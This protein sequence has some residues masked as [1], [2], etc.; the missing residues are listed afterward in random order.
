MKGIKTFRLSLS[1]VLA[2]GILF[3]SF[4]VALADDPPADRI[5]EDPYASWG[6]GFLG[7]RATQ[8]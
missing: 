8:S 5:A 1:I 6:E 2:L 7:L 4:G 3:S